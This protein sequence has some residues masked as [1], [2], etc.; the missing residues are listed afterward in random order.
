M[1]LRKFILFGLFLVV[2]E[3]NQTMANKNLTSIRWAH[4]VNSQKLL[5]ESLNG[6]IKFSYLNKSLIFYIFRPN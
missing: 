2:F 1:E 4:A 6:K 5:D 3:L